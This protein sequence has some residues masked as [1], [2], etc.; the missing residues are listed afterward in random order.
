MLGNIIFQ[1][2]M[3]VIIWDIYLRIGG[4]TTTIKNRILYLLF[5]VALCIWGQLIGRYIGVV[6][7]LV[8][9]VTLTFS[10]QLNKDVTS[11]ERFFL[12]FY[13]VVLVDLARR[14]LAT[15]FF[16]PI[17]GVAASTLNT[18]IWWSMVPLAFVMLTVRIVDFI[19]HLDFTD[20]LKVATQ[21]EKKNRLGLVNML[22]LVYYLVIFLVSTFDTYFPELH[23]ESK[24]RQPLVLGYLYLLLFVLGAVNQFAKEKIEQDLAMKQANYLDDLKRENTR[25]ESLYRDLMHVRS[26]YNF[27]LNNLRDIERTGDIRS[28]KKD[29]VD[30]YVNR[31]HYSFS[32]Q[33]TDLD[34][35]QNPSIHSLLSS[36]YH[37]AQ[38]YRIN[39]HAEIPDPVTQNYLTD[40]DLAVVLGHLM[41]N[42]IDGARKA[43]DGFISL[44]YFD[45]EDC[46][47]F[48]V[49]SAIPD[50]QVP[51]SMTLSQF[52]NSESGIGLNAVQD[53]L[54]RYPNTSFSV[55]S[56]NHKMMQIL[57]MR[58]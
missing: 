43:S 40:L 47:S 36:K 34:N 30:L 15:F 16:P 12:G 1:V 23:L 56:Q 4:Q 17:L 20:I 39:I 22:L 42:A 57:E 46:Q 48:I 18:N 45:E 2:L 41:D 25:V 31:D 32:T 10:Y 28:Y 52:P 21:Q 19:L 29:L 9:I 53:I 55:R 27:L 5:D 44:A 37:E 33:V 6:P 49:E 51:L 26:N 13:P 58:P 38:M 7:P 50:E 35:I 14:F 8:S 3:F 24:L 11:V 54:E